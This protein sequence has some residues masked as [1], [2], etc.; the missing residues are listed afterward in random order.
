MNTPTQIDIRVK[1]GTPEITEEILRRVRVKY[2]DVEIRTEETDDLSYKWLRSVGDATDCDI[3]NRI[4]TETNGLPAYEQI[5]P[6][7]LHH[8]YF[9]VSEIVSEVLKSQGR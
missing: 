9:V 8:S 3:Q 6:S 5:G 7:V 1:R 4:G 2:P